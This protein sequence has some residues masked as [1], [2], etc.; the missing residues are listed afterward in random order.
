VCVYIYIYVCMYVYIYIVMCVYMYIH[1]YTDL[2]VCVY[3]YI[4]MCVCVCIYIYIYVCNI[5][6]I[7]DIFKPASITKL[8]GLWLN[9]SNNLLLYVLTLHLSYKCKSTHV[10]SSLG[11]SCLRLPHFHWLV[12]CVFDAT[13]LWIVGNSLW[14]RSAE[15]GP[16]RARTMPARE[17]FVTLL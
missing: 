11:I 14:Q 8:N 5:Y 15:K 4:F 13:P 10:L 1:I 17:P 16:W 12:I 2:Y 9:L 6:V 7:W 3:I